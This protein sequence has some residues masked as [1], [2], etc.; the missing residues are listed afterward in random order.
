MVASNHSFKHFTMLVYLSIFS[1]TFVVLEH[2]YIN[3]LLKNIF[4]ENS[5]A[6]P[7]VVTPKVMMGA[8]WNPN[9]QKCQGQGLTYAPDVLP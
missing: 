4:I 6:A 2:K 8:K 7:K 3:G 9:L 5:T 1:V